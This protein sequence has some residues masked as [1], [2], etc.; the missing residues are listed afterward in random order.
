MHMT[1]LY[2]D[3]KDGVCLLSLLEVLTGEELVIILLLLRYTVT[4]TYDTDGVA[5]MLL[6][7]SRCYVFMSLLSNACEREAVMSCTGVIGATHAP[8]FCTRNLYKKHGR[9][10]NTTDD[11]SRKQ[12][13]EPTDQTSPF[14]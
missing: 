2:E 13:T 6:L 12:P 3:I 11:A 4:S 5:F 8:E 1:D 10:Q 9:Q 7:L 14:W